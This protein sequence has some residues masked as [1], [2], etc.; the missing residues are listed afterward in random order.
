[1]DH[2]NAESA[3]KQHAELISALARDASTLGREIVDIS[4]ILDA[5]SDDA[6]AQVNALAGLDGTVSDLLSANKKTQRCAAAVSERSAK[7]MDVL[8]N[9]L[10]IAER[11]APAL[12]DLAA[13]VS[14]LATRVDDIETMLNDVRSS[15]STI[16]SIAAQV[17]ILAINAK[18]EAARAGEAGRGFAVVAEAV[19]ELSKKT[20]GAAKGIDG[21]V[22]SLSEWI[23]T[24]GRD[25]LKY[26]EAA[27]VVRQGSNDLDTALAKI[28]EAVRETDRDARTI[29]DAAGA[30]SK[31]GDQFQPTFQAVTNASVATM[32]NIDETKSRSTALIDT[33]ERMVQGTIAIGGTS[34]DANYIQRVQR[35]AARLSA[36]LTE[37]VENGDISERELFSD[38]YE[39][40]AGTNP[41]QFMAPFTKLTDRLFQD[42][43]EAALSHTPKVI[44]CAAVDRQG[45]LPTHNKQFSSP[46]S[47]DPVWNASHCRNRRMFNDRVGLKAG[48]NTE[49][50]L[51]QV[52][53]RD[54]GGGDFRMMKDLSSPI[55]IKGRHW[56]GLRL[57]Y[58]F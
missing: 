44:F 9:S 30:V 12:Q 3:R 42:I 49:P 31:A 17:N 5:I 2:S 40:I 8:D 45:Y 20:T 28:S 47:K 1:M 18:I 36:L 27:K 58:S 6:S 41:Q 25:A 54:M 13:W 46:Q 14:R 48:R 37:A 51:L 34:E 11:N 21:Q 15:N 23:S 35:D 39:P 16:S 50:F 55:T 33:S 7:T 22:S 10:E 32:S 38:S 56:G 53:R 19:N 57:A 24:L 52:Y 26:G 4:G 43:Q 29:A